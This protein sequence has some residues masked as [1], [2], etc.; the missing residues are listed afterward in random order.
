MI[1]NK[2]SDPFCFLPPQTQVRVNVEA[3]NDKHSTY[4][5]METAHKMLDRFLCEKKIP[6]ETLAKQLGIQP[7]E[8]KSLYSVRGY[9]QLA[10]IVSYKLIC[11]YCKT[12]WEI[13][14]VT[15]KIKQ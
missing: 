14:E 13:S 6:Y 8:L 3:F 9:K 5:N 2:I 4:L 1:T 7:R 10:P 12:R 11:L 15:G